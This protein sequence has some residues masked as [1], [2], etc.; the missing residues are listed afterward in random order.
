MSKMSS[1]C[2]FGHLKHKLWPKKRSG[3]KLVVWLPTTKSRESTWF[4]CVQAT[5]N[6]PLESSQWRL[7]LFFKPHCD[8]RFSCKVMCP[9]VAKI[10][11]VGISGLPLG[12]P[13]TKSDLDVAPWRGAEYTIRGKV[14]A[15]PKSGSCWVLCV[16]VAR[17]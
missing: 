6:I 1:H 15:S 8:R 3:V 2:P 16:R 14:V 7:Q 5:C 4:L 17:G 12:N 10:P 11:I 13:G 9:K